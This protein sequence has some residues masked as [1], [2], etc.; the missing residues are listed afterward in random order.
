MPTLIAEDVLLMLL[1]RSGAFV[2]NDNR[3]PALA[4]ALLAEL[5]MSGA[6]EIETEKGLWK[7]TRVVVE[8]PDTVTDP[9]LVE[10][11]QE[12]EAKKRSAQDLV[13]RLGKNLPD[14]LCLRLVER[15]LLRR[16]E[17]KVIGL[18]PRTRWPLTGS[19]HE[20]ELRAGVRRALV[21]G[22]DPDVRT[23]TVIAVLVA[24][25]VVHKV[26]DRGPMSKRDLKK[27]AEVIAE[28]G[29]ATEAVRKA[30]QAAQAAVM[31]GVTAA[32]VAGTA[33]S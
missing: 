1:D 3:K 33:G 17:S 8:D 4:G 14:R 24:A 25:D 23:A 26:V 20:Q 10:A 22:E 30:I 18:F 2:F 7:R 5:A 19:E 15:G 21:E 32:T 28:G 6:A 9:L 16:E 12:I 13:N 29:W 11:L 31:A 27:R